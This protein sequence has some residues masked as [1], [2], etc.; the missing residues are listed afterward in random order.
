MGSRSLDELSLYPRV[1]VRREGTP[2]PA[3]VCVVYWMQR[4]QRAVDNPA[5]DV[6]V[7]AANALRKPL[8]TFLGLVH[9]YP[10]ANL[11][12]YTFLAQG[13]PNLAQR[14]GRRGAA[15]VLC[16]DPDH[17]L[18]DFCEEAKPS[19]VVGDENPDECERGE[20][21][22]LLED[23]RRS[24]LGPISNVSVC[25]TG[26]SASFWNGGS[27]MGWDVRARPVP[28]YRQ[29]PPADK[30]LATQTPQSSHFPGR[31]VFAPSLFQMLGR[32]F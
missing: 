19:L 5:L 32:K 6:A 2:N 28:A 25:G 17:H 14:L 8:V 23:Y 4:A 3:G 29:C 12:H 15:F 9:F 22:S 27:G 26:L 24:M 30:S 7:E 13:I 16:R 20:V 18:A 11:R 1:T 10:N 21:H 31:E